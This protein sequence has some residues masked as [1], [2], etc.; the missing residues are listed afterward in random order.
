M[1]KMKSKPVKTV[2]VGANRR[3]RIDEKRARMSA[4]VRRIAARVAKIAVCVALVGG[5]VYAVFT[6]APALSDRVVSAVKSGKRLPALVT[7]VGCSPPVQASLKRAID[8]MAAFDS[9]AFD[10]AGILRAA[11]AIREIEKVGVKTVRAASGDKA[12]QITVVER[13]PVAI[14]HNGG[15]F[16]VDRKGVCFSPVPGRFYDLPLLAYGGR[17]LGDTVD[18]ELFNTIKKTARGLGGAF[19]RELSEINLSCAS[20]VNL[21]FRSSDTEYKVGAR[22]VESRL[23][24]VKTLKERLTNE[25]SKM[26]RVDLRYRNLAFVTER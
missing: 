19:F 24:H 8:S 12:T 1:K 20:E 2:R 21:V 14:V 9:S 22:D 16:L 4:M 26:L 6:H 23:V 15:V 11:S 5:V 10:K 25:S 13:K 3:M 7:I 18:M 17:A